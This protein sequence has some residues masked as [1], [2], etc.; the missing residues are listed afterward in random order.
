MN[1][2]GKEGQFLPV[3]VTLHYGDIA[4]AMLGGSER[5][6]F[7]AVGRKFETLLPL[8]SWAA[9]SPSLSELRA[10]TC[11]RRYEHVLHTAA[12]KPARLESKHTFSFSVGAWP[13]PGT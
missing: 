7:S 3:C 13:G 12:V 9:F 2:R 11:P 8:S 4:R 10:V 6:I 5:G 1:E